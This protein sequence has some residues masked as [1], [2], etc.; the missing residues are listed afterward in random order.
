MSIIHWQVNAFKWLF[1]FVL[2]ILLLSGCGTN[3]QFVNPFSPDAEQ[4]ESSAL[5]SELSSP[6]LSVEIAPIAPTI[7]PSP[8]A[9]ELPAPKPTDLA[10]SPP[11][12]PSDLE[13]SEPEDPSE[14]ETVETSVLTE[15]LV[16]E[17][18]E[19]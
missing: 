10:T 1:P 3:S 2:S 7:A 6:E 12:D 8:Q 15:L 19:Q 18:L 16:G 5:P 17:Q 14:L 4:V 9:K 11:E 13:T